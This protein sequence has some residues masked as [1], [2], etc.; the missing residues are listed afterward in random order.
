MASESKVRLVDSSAPA[1]EGFNA[2]LVGVTLADLIQMKCMSGATESVRVS[3]SG[4]FGILHFEQGQL[5]QAATR[6]LRGDAAVLELLNW[7]TGDCTPV[8]ATL[9]QN[10]TVR[11]SWQSL[12]LAAVKATDERAH[13]LLPSTLPAEVSDNRFP[14]LPPETTSVR[15]NMTGQ[16]LSSTGPAED[17]AAATAYVLHVATHIGE[18]L[19]LD[20]FQGCEFR[21]GEL[22]T[23]VVKQTDGEVLA[24][25]S[26]VDAEVAEA[27]AALGL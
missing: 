21:N 18:A 7:R 12:L 9:P 14:P 23:L 22:H 11:R 10:S 8:A 27:R 1:G 5:T 13:G 24:V 6:E 25:Q 4:R 17:L 16:V 3:S 15:L 2:R 20:P 26:P 19:G